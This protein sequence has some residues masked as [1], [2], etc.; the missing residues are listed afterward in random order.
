MSVRIES[1]GS[2]AIVTLDRLE[3]LNALNGETLELLEHGFANLA[4]EP[5]L[6]AV[7]VTGAGK[8]FVAGAD[9]KEMA[10]LTPEQ[11]RA[12]AL[13]GQRVF[14]R[15]AAFPRPVIAA[16]NGFALGGGCE[17]AMACDLRIGSE[18][19]KLGQPEV[20]LGVTPG[21]GGT[22][23]LARLVGP[24]RA[25]YLLFTGEVIPAEKALAWGLLDEVHPP[26]GLMPRCMALA[27]HLAKQ[28]PMAITACKLALDRGLDRPLRDGL[29]GEAEAFGHCFATAD[30]K[31]G[32]QA[33]IDKRDPQFSGA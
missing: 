30:Q 6:R 1:L 2:V 7:I 16:V 21:F 5:E 8:A 24:S 19:A 33:F 4:S 18:R 11:A 3:A 27:E 26:E 15:I 10:G 22:Q 25:K 12:Y 20:H 29:D 23:R 28:G 9:I 17:L 13:R 14:D 32:M 31:E